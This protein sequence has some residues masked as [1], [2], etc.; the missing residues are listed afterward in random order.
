M[1]EPA[2]FK[3]QAEAVQLRGK[4]R[5]VTRVN[6]KVLILGAGVIALLMMAG[7]ALAFSP[8]RL[9]SGDQ[10]REVYATRNNVPEGL[11]NMP[12][13]YDELADDPVIT[14]GPALPGEF[15]AALL[16]AERD[17]GLL[18]PRLP[19]RDEPF[20]PDHQSDMLRAARLRDAQLTR[21]ANQAPV[22]FQLSSSGLS[23]STDSSR[24]QPAAPPV[25]R[26]DDLFASIVEPGSTSDPNR[27]DLKLTFASRH[28]EDIYNP[29]QMETPASP[30][31]LMAGTIIPASLITGVNS[32][33][34]GTVIAQV[35]QNVFDTVTGRYL[36][37]PQGSRLI[38]RYDS[39]ITFGQDRALLVWDRL[40]FPN[41]T[42]VL[43]G[44]LPGADKI[45]QAGLVDRTDHHW[46][47]VFGAA[48]LATVL[49]VGS[50]LAI[51]D[52]ADEIGRA[53][54]DAF[55]DTAGRTGQRVVDRQL[56]IQP[57]IRI[58]PG[59]PVRVMVTRDLILVPYTENGGIR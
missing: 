40:I 22:F 12:S 20:R 39:G 15:G 58:R 10:P 41:G 42:S 1:T 51:D 32:D 7:I 16:Q 34:P 33:L 56:G 50:E 5:P 21:D 24:T 45:G 25:H 46:R 11:T 47:R 57:T 6:R 23:S 54:R 27:Q 52:D 44:G 49:G 35:T 19:Y 3:E 55:Q 48:I 18:P 26:S 17:E 38:G 53:V 4:P 37:L 14:L 8:P 2:S 36:L 9:S 28:S 29:Y 30:Y 43:I 13:S 59:W 31:Q